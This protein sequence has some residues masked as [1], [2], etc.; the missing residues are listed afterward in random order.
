MTEQKKEHVDGLFEVHSEGAGSN[1]RKEKR[2]GMTPQ[3]A[4]RLG[5]KA[6]HRCRG[7]ACQKQEKKEENS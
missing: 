4:G 7:F 2:K 6:P 3:E 5:G 1:E